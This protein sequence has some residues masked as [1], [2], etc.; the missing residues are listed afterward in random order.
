MRTVP[1][2]GI[3]PGLIHTGVVSLAFSRKDQDITITHAV[4]DGPDAVATKRWI[5]P[6][7]SIIFVEG[8]RP[9]SNFATDAK[10]VAA[11]AEFRKQ[12]D[13][14]V[15]NNMGAKKVVKRPLMEMLHVW[16]FPSVTHHQDLRAAARIALLGML[17]DSHLNQ[18]LTDVVKAH[19]C[20]K[21]WLVHS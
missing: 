17:K 10:M 19:L 14:T 5:G 13:A 15:V 2:I 1:I 7:T 12:L 9:R 21:D 3:D 6:G 8:Y 20:G 11:V 16:T 4:I 18:L